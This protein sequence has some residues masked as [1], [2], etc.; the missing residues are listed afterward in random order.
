MVQRLHATDARAVEVVPPSAE[1]CALFMAA[2][3]QDS[4]GVVDRTEFFYLVEFIMVREVRSQPSAHGL[5]WRGGN[6]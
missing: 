1:E 6:G 3:D 5:L 2:F 4:D